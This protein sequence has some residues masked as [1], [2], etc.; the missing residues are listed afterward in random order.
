M[1][2]VRP[3]EFSIGV[4]A[5]CNYGFSPAAITFYVALTDVFGTN[6]IAVESAP[7]K[8]DFRVADL[9]W[10]NGDVY[11][12]NGSACAHLTMEN[13]TATTRVSLDFRVIAGS[14]WEEHADHYTQTQGYF[15]CA[16][17]TNTNCMLDKRSKW[18]RSEPL[19][20]TDARNGFP[21]T[22]K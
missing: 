7:G 5:D 9:K 4:H 1:R 8:G 12:F 17:K 21:F 20:E 18:I 13:T 6:S 14:L 11:R 10:R 3:G 22:N 16:K 19:P 15:V 2:I